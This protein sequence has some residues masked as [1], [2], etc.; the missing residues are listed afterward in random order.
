MKKLYALLLTFFAAG[1]SLPAQSTNENGYNLSLGASM[2]LLAGEGEEIV[3]R[4]SY[5]GDKLSQLLWY[6]EPLFYAGIDINYS[7]HKPGNSIDFFTGGS[8]KF[9]F[10]G[11]TGQVED[12]DWMSKEY[13]DFLTHYSV[14]EN[15]TR[16]ASLIDANV[17]VSFTVFEKYLIKTFLAYNCMMFSWTAIRGSFL[18]PVSTDGH[19]YLPES[20]KVGTYKQ[21]WNIISPG[22]SF[23]GA[24]NRWFDIDISLKLSPVVWLSAKDEHLMRNLVVTEKFMG[25]LFVEPSLLFSFKQNDFVTWALFFSYK[26]ISGSRGDSIYK[27]QGEQA[28]K[29]KNLGGAG[30]SAFDIGIMAKINIQNLIY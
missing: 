12:R 11:K 8:F 14:H 18:Y 10:P 3:Y 26:N 30:Y 20:V 16:S 5:S 1:L 7:W 21:T 4:Y 24:F 22:I 27:Q 29:A 23:Y 25:G 19:S 17:G 15:R 13:A 6:M 2:G 9:G 28:M